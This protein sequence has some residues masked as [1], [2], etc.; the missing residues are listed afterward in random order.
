MLY[1]LTGSDVMKAKARAAAL[2]K[3][4]E[5][6]R[7]GDDGE[8]FSRVPSYLGAR[9]L[10]AQKTA[11]FLDRP[12]EDA[13]GKT[14]IAEH[15]KDFAEA[16]MPIIVIEPVLDAATKKALGKHAELEEFELKRE[17]EPALPSVFA[18]TDAFASGDRKGAGYSIGGLSRAARQRKKY[19]ARSP[20]RLARWSS[21]QKRKAPQKQA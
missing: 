13:G 17:A 10:F 5:I 20:G 15:A 19:T 6:V 1:V 4:Y 2:A 16:D 3:G 21:H 8:A 18:L 12:S 14:P 9:G 7:F 11:L